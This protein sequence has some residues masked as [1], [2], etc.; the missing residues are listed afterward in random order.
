MARNDVFQNSVQMTGYV[1]NSNLR[2][3][4]TKAT[5][6]WHPNEEYIS[7]TVNVATDDQALNV[8][9]VNFFVYEKRSDRDGN[10]IPNDTYQT[11]DQIIDGQ[12]YERVGNQAMKVRIS[13]SV[14]T[15]D[16]YSTRNNRMVTSQRVNGRFI[17]LMPPNTSV[18]PASFNVNMVML[19][20]TDREVEGRPP[21][22]DVKGY[23]FNYNG[24]RLFPVTF[25]CHDESGINFVQSLDASSSNPVVLNV[26]GNIQTTIIELQNAEQEAVA[27]GFGVRPA[28]SSNSTRTVRSWVVTG[29]DSE[30]CP[31]F[32]DSAPFTKSDMKRLVDERNVRL[33]SMQQGSNYR[34]AQPAV[35]R[36]QM[37]TQSVV[38]DEEIPF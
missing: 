13:A 5:N 2:K 22:V 12:T 6:Q 29:A 9:P 10:K 36:Q 16:F 14:D 21:F 34:S 24:S 20:V 31:Q 17:H 18:T 38:D 4:V 7:G 1:F 32:G 35:T 27:S 33:Q 8:V 26:W 23:V 30:A 28:V 37:T 3:G 25:E 15:N 19:G 11:L